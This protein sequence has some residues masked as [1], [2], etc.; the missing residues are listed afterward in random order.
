MKIYAQEDEDP[1]VSILS[2]IILKCVEVAGICYFLEQWKS[3][4]IKLKRLSHPST[5]VS[6]NLLEVVR[7]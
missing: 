2:L 5:R 4:E 7:C 6:Q 1:G 3:W